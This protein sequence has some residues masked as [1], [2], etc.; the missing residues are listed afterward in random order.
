MRSPATAPVRDDRIA[1]APA[2]DR[3]CI[4][5]ATDWARAHIAAAISR[6]HAHLAGGDTISP[7]SI[8]AVDIARIV[9]AP[10]PVV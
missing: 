5:A 8:S 1:Q 6:R 2:T 4:A 9:P 7:A 3:A 10:D